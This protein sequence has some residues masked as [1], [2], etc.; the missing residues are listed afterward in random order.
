MWRP[1]HLA[2]GRSTCSA[3]PG[4]RRRFSGA[5]SCPG[6]FSAVQ[7]MSLQFWPIQCS[8]RQVSVVQ[9]FSV[10]LR[11]IQLSELWL[12]FVLHILQAPYFLLFLFGFQGSCLFPCKQADRQGDQTNLRCAGRPSLYATCCSCVCIQQIAPPAAWGQHKTCCLRLP[13]AQ[14]VVQHSRAACCAVQ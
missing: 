14:R 6:L 8:S 3:C 10:Q 2:L 11:A 13:C 1:L 7:G 9:C 12:R 5:R 4:R